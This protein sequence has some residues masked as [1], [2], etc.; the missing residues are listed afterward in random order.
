VETL[1]RV[2]ATRLVTTC[3]H[4]LHTL[5]NEYPAFGGRFTVVHHTELIQ[6]LLQAGRLSMK[7]G[8]SLEKVTFHD[9]CYLGRHNAILDAPRAV[10]STASAALMEMPRH[11]R[12]SFC[13]GAGG[14]QM[15]KEEERGDE[16]VSANR[17]RE[18]E[19]TGATTLGVGCPFCM[20]M[21]SDAASQGESRTLQVRDVA[22]IV[23]ERM[24]L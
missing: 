23:A 22:E 20:I 15:W 24:G 13:C 19:A 10:L 3:P 14:A 17:L 7:P 21:L 12:K 2:A 1:N 5:K 11:G 8:V 16:R 4:C 9:P 6:E 18:A